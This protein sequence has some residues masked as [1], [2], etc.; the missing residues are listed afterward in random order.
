MANY[1]EPIIGLTVMD[2]D[3]VF[4]LKAKRGK[5]T[6]Y[7]TYVIIQPSKVSF[8]DLYT[9]EKNTLKI[10]TFEN[11]DALQKKYKVFRFI[12]RIKEITDIAHRSSG[13]ITE[14]L[15]YYIIRNIWQ[16]DA[17]ADLRDWTE[18]EEGFYKCGGITESSNPSIEHGRLLKIRGFDSAYGD[19]QA[20]NVYRSEW[21]DNTDVGKRTDI[22]TRIFEMVNDEGY[23]LSPSQ[24]AGGRTRRKIV[25]NNKKKTARRHK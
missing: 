12:P 16:E 14:G 20:F 2:E 4:I 11:M 23:P 19:A 3:Q 17:N 25:K 5:K 13:R 18:Q 6:I 1:H 24:S 7:A 22:G 15:N 9:I 10:H 8:Q 21:T